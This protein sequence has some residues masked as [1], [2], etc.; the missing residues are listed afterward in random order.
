MLDEAALLEQ[1]GRVEEAARVREEAMALKRKVAAASDDG[2]PRALALRSVEK[3]IG[4]LENVEGCEDLREGLLETA[5]R[6]RASLNG[7]G[8]VLEDGDRWERNLIS[9]EEFWR[10]NLDTLR[11]A[12]KGLA[13]LGRH[14]AAEA[15]ERAIGAREMLVSGR[16]DEEAQRVARGGPGDGDM[17][18]L[19]LKAAGCWREVKQPENAALCEELGRRFQRIAQKKHEGAA[20]EGA[21]F[22]RRNLDTLRIARKGLAEAERRDGAELMERAIRARELLIEG[23]PDMAE[24]AMKEGPGDAELAELLLASA[25]CWRELKQPEKAFQCEE[26]GRYFQHAVEKRRVEKTMEFARGER[27]DGP[28]PDDRLARLE[29]RLDRMERML[30]ETLQRLEQQERERRAEGERDREKERAREREDAGR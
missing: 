26:L 18:E 28:G 10:R 13:E 23:K 17:A 20:A 7:G 30:H 24:R 9:K 27:R 5:G 14:D 11:I 3:A 6:L 1:A 25:G 2:D 21:D 16:K 12:R 15:M 19:L 4:A 29:E 8:L 22:W